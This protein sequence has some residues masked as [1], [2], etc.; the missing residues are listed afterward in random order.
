M[1]VAVKNKLVKKFLK[2]LLSRKMN[3]ENWS[4]N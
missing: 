4:R 3:G 2:K 1:K